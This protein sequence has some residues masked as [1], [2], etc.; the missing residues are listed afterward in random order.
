MGIYLKYLP[1]PV[2]VSFVSREV[3]QVPKTFNRLWPQEVVCIIRLKFFDHLNHV[4][5]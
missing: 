5:N 2:L 3:I 4:W 1:S